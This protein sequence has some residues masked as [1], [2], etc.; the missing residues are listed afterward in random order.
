MTME[1]N[2][3]GS[4]ATDGGFDVEISEVTTSDADLLERL[5]GASTRIPGLTLVTSSN[6]EILKSLGAGRDLIVSGP[7]R[8]ASLTCAALPAIAD[9]GLVLV[10]TN[11]LVSIRKLKTRFESLNIRTESFDLAPTKPEKRCIWEALDRDEIQILLVT[12]GRLSSRR[13]R[14]R[15]KRR[16]ASLIIIDQAQLMSPWSHRFEPNYRFLGNF[17]AS[18]ENSGKSPQKVALVWNPTPRINH[19]LSRLL[20]LKNPIEGRLAGCSKPELGL[21]AK[22][23]NTDD[24]RGE[25]LTDALDQNETQCVIYCNNLKQLFDTEKLLAD[26]RE[27][28]AVIRPGLPEFQ[29]SSIRKRFE[30]GELRIVATIGPFLSQIDSAPGVECVIFNG[31]PE[32]PE[33]LAREILTI[34]DSHFIRATII[35]SEKDYF[36]HRF[37]IDKNY[38]DALVMRACMQGVRDVFGSKLAVT[39]DTLVSHVKMATP[40][41]VDDVEHCIQ[42]LFRE[43]V[44][45][46]V[47]DNDTQTMFVRFSLTLE[48]EVNFW[49][50]YPLRKID[51]VARLDKM[52]EI[53]LKDGDFARALQSSIRS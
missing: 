39:P 22:V 8:L 23:A 19:D 45:E 27:D 28:F 3:A 49:H 50:E 18:L 4:P 38:P 11:S 25:I 1:F 2:A 31:M 35:T 41:A 43:G 46:K 13:F 24:H 17:L 10:V 21:V 40:Y 14:E 9:Y 29:M 33:C 7:D 53:S 37:L 51:H 15:L 44:L 30:S 16:N 34:E 12:P 47:F 26:R 5:I 48:E 6:L 36:Q 20:G 52:R 42:V 32:S